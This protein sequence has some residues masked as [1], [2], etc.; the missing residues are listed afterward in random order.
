MNDIPLGVIA[1]N[2]I[3]AA[4]WTLALSA[5]AF[6]C[7][8]TA[9]LGL[10]LLRVSHSRG[11]LQAARLY[12]DA[13]QGTPLLMQLFLVFFGLPLLGIDVSPWL[14][15]AVG[16]TLYASAYLGEIWRGCV[17]AIPSSQWDAAASLGLR[18]LARLRLVILPQA[19]RIAIPP[20]VGFLVQLLKATA[21]ASIVGFRE[22]TR[23]AQ[24][25]T[26]ATFR[27]FAVYGLVALIYFALCLPLTVC[28]HTLELRLRVFRR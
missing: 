14:A 24:I 7:G 23:T 25:I 11:A 1:W 13:F 21:V 8:S 2:L 27:P 10:T 3:L 5:V 15:A 26:N 17:Q 9:G 16:L 4:R 22:L 19:L 20:T 12:I 6:A 28:A 18:R